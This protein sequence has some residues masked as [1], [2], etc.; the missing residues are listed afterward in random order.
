MNNVIA[1][2]AERLA[3]VW[4]ERIAGSKITTV[5]GILGIGATFVSQLTTY[6]P[7]K[8]Q[9]FVALAGVIIAGTA[10][11]LA[12][13]SASSGTN[14]ATP[15]PASSTSTQKLGA[16]MLCFCL[17]SCLFQTGCNAKTAA[18]DIVAWTPTLQSAVAA[19]DATSSVLVPEAAAIFAAATV[20]F[21]AASNLIAAQAKAYLANP[22]ATLLSTLQSAVTTFQQSVNAAVLQAAKITNPASQQKAL[23]DIGAV[24]T[25]VNTILSVITS[26]SGKSAVARM[27]S[28]STIKLAAV[29]PYEDRQQAI[30]LLA[31][32]YQE[33]TDQARLQLFVGTRQLQ[34]AGF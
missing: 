6:I 30:A 12:K 4:I 32:H 16:I 11:I 1:A 22:S 7:V 26:I 24:G 2:L 19:V 29:E 17:A 21:D 20:G 15:A 31:D 33:S 23:A 14:P 27:A 10:A 3:A 25:I 28:E 8:Y 13:D 9:T 18:Q 34:S 5:A